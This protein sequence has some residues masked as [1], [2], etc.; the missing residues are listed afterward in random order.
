MNDKVLPFFGEQ[1]GMLTDRGT[2][3]CDHADQHDYQP[4]LAINK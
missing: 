1:D 2:E 4:Y 3:Y